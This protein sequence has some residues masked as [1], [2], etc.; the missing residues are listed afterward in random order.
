MTDALVAII[1]DS[2]LSLDIMAELLEEEGFSVETSSDEALAI[3]WAETT[4][5]D[6]LL[7]DLTLAH[8][9]GEEVVRQL[10][11]RAR[12]RCPIVIYSAHDRDHVETCAKRC[13]A[14]GFVLKADDDD[15]VAQLRDW[16]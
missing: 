6:L 13:G 15:F 1:D 3:E 11:Q 5:P 10:K 4:S 8:T 12:L 14:D 7:V 9:S 16:L 2:E